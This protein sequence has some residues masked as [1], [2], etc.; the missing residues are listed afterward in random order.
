MRPFRRRHLLLPALLLLAGCAGLALQDLITP[1]QFSS[2]PDQTSR[3]RLLPPSADRPYGGA[4]LRLWTRVENPNRFGL[5]LTGIEGSL[6]LED[7]RAA[8]VD[9]PLGLPLRALGDTI[10]PMDL[11]VSFADLPGIAETVGQVVSGS[12][13]NYRIDG[14]FGVDAGALGQ[15]SFGPTTIL[16][17]TAR[18]R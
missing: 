11:S 17:G 2:A 15:P 1:P 8:A 14:T 12:S 6:F 5:T 3:I 18:T 9:L 7:E 10:I 16:R 4:E 13:F